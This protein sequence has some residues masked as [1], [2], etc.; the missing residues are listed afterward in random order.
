AVDLITAAQFLNMI[1]TAPTLEEAKARLSQQP[2]S[3]DYYTNWM[4]GQKDLAKELSTN[5]NV[6]K[7]IKKAPLNITGYLKGVELSQRLIQLDV[8]LAKYPL[9]SAKWRKTHET[10]L[11]TLT[12]L[13][14]EDPDYTNLFPEKPS[15]EGYTLTPFIERLAETGYFLALTYMAL[16]YLERSTD[17]P[18]TE[19]QK[20]EQ[21]NT[22]FT[23]LDRACIRG[24]D[25]AIITTGDIYR[26]M[27]GDAAEDP[28]GAQE[29]YLRMIKHYDLATRRGNP[30]AKA[31]LGNA[32]LNPHQMRDPATGILHGTVA[33]VT[34]ALKFLNE[35]ADEDSTFAY[36]YLGTYYHKKNKLNRAIEYFE[37]AAQNEHI[38]SMREL[39]TLY[40]DKAKHSKPALA[41]QLKTKA[42]ENMY[43]IAHLYETAHCLTGEP[44][45]KEAQT[46][47]LKSLKIEGGDRH[48]P[49]IK[50]ALAL[51]RLATT[52]VQGLPAPNARLAFTYLKKAADLGDMGAMIQTACLFVQP[53]HPTLKED[54]AQ[55]RLYLDKIKT[56]KPSLSEADSVFI[57]NTVQKLI[58]QTDKP[59]AVDPEGIKRR[60]L[61]NEFILDLAQLSQQSN[62]VMS[63]YKTIGYIYASMLFDKM[64]AIAYYEKALLLGDLQSYLDIGFICLS[65]NDPE[66]LPDIDYAMRTFKT[67]VKDGLDLTTDVIDSIEAKLFI[68]EQDPELQAAFDKA[69][70]YDIKFLKDYNWMEHTFFSGEFASPEDQKKIP[71]YIHWL[72]AETVLDKDHIEGLL[73]GFRK[74]YAA[75]CQ[76]TT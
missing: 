6:R 14:K 67:G 4:D 49:Q 24:A 5:K 61:L 75:A 22:G 39:D 72:E 56:A 47:Y 27:L 37:K 35:A 69:I 76:Q 65:N 25:E 26:R 3:W 55:G 38:N 40:A 17:E 48:E 57:N 44:D 15:I 7:K 74:C 8:D 68:Y 71:H 20:D 46:C 34:P 32:L 51:S 42:A 1:V 64:R 19:D 43:M 23:Y 30:N 18:L 59:Q 12:Q 9:Y 63:A 10:Y 60:L 13:K 66:T 31:R 73:T 50:S 28:K 58:A 16:F 36:F 33:Q 45:F 41:A 52:P 2:L 11:D 54:W 21:F 70:Y 29:F 53:D 62:V